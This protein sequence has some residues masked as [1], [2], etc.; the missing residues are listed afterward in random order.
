MKNELETGTFSEDEIGIRRKA[1]K[2]LEVKASRMLARSEARWPPDVAEALN[3]E[4][5]ACSANVPNNNGGY[6]GSVIK[7][8][9]EAD[10]A[11]MGRF[12][13]GKNMGVLCVRVEWI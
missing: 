12:A 3:A 7:A 4:L 5:E 10:Y 9:W 2:E 1:I 6:I 8:D 13:S 11:I